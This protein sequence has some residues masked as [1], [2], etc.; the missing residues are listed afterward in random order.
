MV[1]VTF[2]CSILHELTDV[3][4]TKSLPRV[5]IIVA[6]GLVFLRR[7]LFIFWRE[8]PALRDSYPNQ[9]VLSWGLLLSEST[10]PVSRFST[11]SKGLPL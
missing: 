4:A 6:K 8:L 3:H 2:D 7:V 11:C 9:L 10:G 1:S 5:A